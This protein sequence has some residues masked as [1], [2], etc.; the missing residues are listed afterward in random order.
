MALPA[1]V[2]GPV[3]CRALAAFAAAFLA[4]IMEGPTTEA[5]CACPLRTFGNLP[6]QAPADPVR[7]PKRFSAEVGAAGDAEA[8]WFVHLRGDRNVGLMRVT[9][10]VL[11]LIGPRLLSRV[12]PRAYSAHPCGRA[13]LAGRR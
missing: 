9:D 4:L 2:R 12:A 8:T 6:R 10:G 1:G 13:W 11:D 7:R 5:P 3:D